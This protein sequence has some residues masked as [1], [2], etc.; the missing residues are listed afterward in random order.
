[1][2][3]L[4][5]ILYSWLTPFCHLY[6]HVPHQEHSMIACLVEAPA[7]YPIGRFVPTWEIAAHSY[8]SLDSCCVTQASAWHCP[9]WCVCCS[10]AEPS[11]LAVSNRAITNAASSAAQ[12]PELGSPW[13]WAQRLTSCTSCTLMQKRFHASHPISA[14]LS[15]WVKMKLWTSHKNETPKHGITQSIIMRAGTH[16]PAGFTHGTDAPQCH[17]T[18]WH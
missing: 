14:T 17:G 10:P 16:I 12:D 11:S 6:I 2:P 4:S 1:M 3:C 5:F 9:W 8:I 15:H 7:R 18:G 13:T